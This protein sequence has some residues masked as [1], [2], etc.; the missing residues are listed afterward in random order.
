MRAPRLPRKWV[1]LVLALLVL[2]VG[3]GVTEWWA[4]ADT[5]HRRSDAIAQ[6]ES[7]GGQVRE[8]LESAAVP[9]YFMTH[10]MD[11]SVGA[12]D[13]ILNPTEVA[14]DLQELADHGRF[15]RSVSIA[16]GNRIAY[17]A[18]AAGNQGAL[19]LY[20]PNLPDQWPAIAEMIHGAPS[21]LQGPYNLAQGGRGF[22][23]R[24]PVDLPGTGCW[25]LVSTVLDADAYLT[26]ASLP[27]ESAGVRS[28]R[29][30]TGDGSPGAVF[31]GD[32]TVFSSEPILT[33]VSPLGAQWQLGVVPNPIDTAPARRIRIV[34]FA[35]SAILAVLVFALATSRQR[36]TRLSRRLAQLS[37][38]APGMFFQMRTNPDGTSALPYV[39][40]R[41]REM[42]G[43]DPSDVRDDA[44][45]MWNRV[46]AT[47]IDR[48]RASLQASA[49]AGQAWHE[50]FQMADAHAELRCYLVDA[51]PE[52][53]EG[54]SLLWSGVLTDITDEVAAEEQLRIGASA[55]AS[56]PNGVAIMDADGRVVQV[57]RAFTALTGY[58]LEDVR[59]RNLSFLG[60]GLTPP[61]V[62]EDMRASLERTGSWRGELVNRTRTGQV[63]TQ[64]VSVNPVFDDDGV[65]THLI[66]VISSL[67]LL[68]D[69]VVT[70]LPNRPMLDDRLA[71]AV[72]RAKVA[73]DSVA[74]IVIGIDH[75]RDINESF[76]PRVGDIVLKEVAH[77]VRRAT[78]PGEVVARFGGDEFAIVL[79]DSV[80][81][82]SVEKVAAAVMR[83][84]AR[85]VSVAS[86][87]VHLTASAGISV[88]PN[89]TDS[90][91][92]L[93]ANAS[94]A[95]RFAK[96]HGR[97]KYHYFTASMQ[98]KAR[99]RARL[100]ED[101][102]VALVE[103]QLHLV[104]QPI[105][106]LPSGAIHKAEALLRWQH[107][108]QGPIPPMIFIAIAEQ[109][110]L[111]KDVGDFVFAET[112]AAVR[113]L[114]EYEPAFVISFNMSPL[115]VGD[116]GDLHER[117]LRRMTQE[118]G[119]GSALVLE[120]TEGLMLDRTEAAIAN[121]LSYRESGM[122]FAIDDF[123]TGY[124]SLSYLQELDADYLKIDR[125]FVIDLGRDRGSLALC[126][127][128]ID[129]AHK[130]N[131]K[132]IAEGIETE[133]QR[134]LLTNAGCDFGQGY[135][136]SRPIPIDDII[137]L[138]Q[139][140]NG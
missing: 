57:N 114:R 78:P 4:R 81:A 129:R 37:A 28:L 96:E 123:G 35:V 29:K 49:E 12:A 5:A 75:F 55:T 77:R 93:I 36:R 97:N 106:D 2:A 22:A 50:R 122:Q 24:L 95:M 134:D 61:E 69:D 133:V 124:S 120:M 137:E 139:R 26:D 86:R 41:I 98:E 99:E 20:Y 8:R 43:V 136:F 73:Q 40:P 66:G 113:R 16:P 7:L 13:G 116:E 127:A 90:A 92:E 71:Q 94:Q 117:R 52:A 21:V 130:L 91:D 88:F 31:W 18:P 80:D 89:D 27:A 104:F 107:P 112:L 56:T 45:L 126:E 100:A 110:D 82:P 74:L 108:E 34:G 138:I 67:N 85:P 79:S 68:R 102:R 46:A 135:L 70:G 84:M 48:A 60:A 25:G 6:V 111:I 65:V 44:D 62:Y 9:A 53:S 103:G 121:M 30:V 131:L 3:C 42:F 64:A 140:V 19:G 128:M 83:S 72:D 1:P 63:V 125:A 47:D 119:P 33:A 132:V 118:G 17:V 38:K 115:E 32:P 76:G 87:E 51:T 58:S 39:S 101:L 105:V 59:G 10:S 109:S 14:K 15:V 23:Y 11:A 54:D